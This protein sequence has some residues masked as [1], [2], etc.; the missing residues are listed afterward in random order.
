MVVSQILGLKNKQL[1][2]IR[3]NIDQSMRKLDVFENALANGYKN[4]CYVQD[5]SY[6]RIWFNLELEN[7]DLQ[8]TIE[9]EI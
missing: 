5:H 9:R 2:Y 8:T 6:R 1:S 7:G 3:I 4:N